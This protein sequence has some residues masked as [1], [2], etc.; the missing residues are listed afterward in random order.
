[1]EQLFDYRGALAALNDVD[2]P[3]GHGAVAGPPLPRGAAPP[4]PPAERCFVAFRYL[5]RAPEVATSG[6]SHGLATSGVVGRFVRV[7]EVDTR[8][9]VARIAAVCTK[10]RVLPVF[11][12]SA[13]TARR[14]L[15]MVA[16]ALW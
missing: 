11:V 3:G 5:V 13:D 14:S 1:V 10:E 6:S 12:S 15:V 8:L 7:R 9:V 2:V 4:P 16:P